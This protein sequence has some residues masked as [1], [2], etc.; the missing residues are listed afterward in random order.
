MTEKKYAQH[1]L[2]DF[3][4]E[5]EV[6]F[7]AKPQAYFRGARQL[8]GAQLNMGWQVFT[9]SV[10]LEKE[11]HTHDADEYLVFLGSKLPDVFDF[12]AE[13]ELWIGEEMEKHVI[14]SATIVYIPKGLSHCPL[15]FKRIDEPVLFQA[16]LLTPKFQKIVDGK[17]ITFDGPG[18]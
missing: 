13:I 14:N 11:P 15:N 10:R 18:A 2:T 1:F 4:E 5:M 3:K 16:V 17:E 8:P 6:P 9:Q 12:D 7:L